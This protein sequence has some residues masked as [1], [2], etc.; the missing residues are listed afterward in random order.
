M[1]VRP[2]V[3]AHNADGYTKDILLQDERQV[4]MH[5]GRLRE[6]AGSCGMFLDPAEFPEA[7]LFE[8]ILR[9]EDER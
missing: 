1:S 3:R 4:W 6:R 9:Q 8:I 7:V 5:D 2:V